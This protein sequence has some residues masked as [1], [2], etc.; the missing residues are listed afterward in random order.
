MRNRSETSTGTSPAF[1]A[2]D[3]SIGAT[4]SGAAT[5]PSPNTCASASRT[6][7][8]ARTGA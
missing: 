6:A 5:A 4:G 1:H 7:A 3:Q 8:D 2:S